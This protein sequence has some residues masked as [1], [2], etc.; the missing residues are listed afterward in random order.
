MALYATP[1]SGFPSAK[2]LLKAGVLHPPQDPADRSFPV[3][4]E[5]QREAKKIIFSL[6]F[7]L[8]FLSLTVSLTG[9]H[10]A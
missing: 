4:G 8:H 1:N 7:Y 9:A 2:N 6:S 3:G 10:G 5:H